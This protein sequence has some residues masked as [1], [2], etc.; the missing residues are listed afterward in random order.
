MMQWNLSYQ[1]Q[2]GKDWLATINYLGNKTNHILGAHE[3]NPAVYTGSTTT[4]TTSNTNARRVLSLLN[5]AQGQFYS[6]IAQTDDGN[7]AH[8][9]GLLLSL[10]H[11]FADHF[12]W[13]VNYT[14]AHCIS[15]YDFGGELAG[16]NYQDPNNRA[17]ER[18]PCNFDRRHI[19]NTSLVASSPGIGN[20]FTSSPKTGSLRR[21]SAPIP[22]S[23]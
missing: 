22:D 21:L 11:R 16:N 15:T 6:S 2:I 20:A 4:S 13:L 17:A 14:W 18:G 23:P 7:N 1:R 8:Y 12:T 9:N 10:N 19:F 5:A 3:I